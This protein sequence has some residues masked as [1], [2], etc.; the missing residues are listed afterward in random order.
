[1]PTI[2]PSR[3]EWIQ[4]HV[5]QEV[6]LELLEHLYAERDALEDLIH[7]FEKYQ[8]VTPRRPASRFPWT[9]GA[10]CS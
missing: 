1:M 9:S 2:Y 7:W 3:D 6:R 5:D 8:R 4:H 10:K